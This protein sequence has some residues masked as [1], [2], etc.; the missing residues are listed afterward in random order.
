[1][2]SASGGIARASAAFPNEA[3]SATTSRPG[4]RTVGFE[5]RVTIAFAVEPDAAL[6]VRVLYGG[7]DLEAAFDDG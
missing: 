7:R 4:L 5:R 1:M 2:S 6:I 3:P